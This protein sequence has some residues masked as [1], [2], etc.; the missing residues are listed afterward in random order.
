[1]SNQELRLVI[2]GLRSRLLIAVTPWR[3]THPSWQLVRDIEGAIAAADRALRTLPP[4]PAAL[5][6]EI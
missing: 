6:K 5:K 4:P 1:M 3:C 2:A